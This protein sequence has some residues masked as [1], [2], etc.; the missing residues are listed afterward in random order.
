MRVSI[1]GASGF[2]GRNL[3]NECPPN[4]NIDAFYNS[5]KDFPSTIKRKRTKAIKC[6]LSNPKDVKV[7]KS[8][9]Y[10][11][12]IY[13]AGNTDPQMSF[14][15]PAF[16]LKSNQLSLVNFLENVKIGKIIYFSSGAVY[17]GLKGNVNPNSK[18][19]P[20]LAYSISK[21]SSEQ[22]VKFFKEKGAVDEY[23][24]VRFFG[25]Y[26]PYE[27]KRKITT[28]IVKR[29]FLEKKRD[30]QI[31]GSG[32]NLIDLMYVSD[33]VK[34]IDILSKSSKKNITVD[35]ANK[36]PVQIES[37]VKRC[38]SLF[39]INPTIKKKGISHESIGFRS[40]DTTI[41]RMGF[42]PKVRLEKGLGLLADHL[43][44]I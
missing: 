2:I 7:L 34:A 33:T 38:A 22:Y 21:L 24:I 1:V 35:L 29:F 30:I 5:S 6:D 27:P 39:N 40:N 20:K 44:K 8:K 37:L 36:N 12:C 19:D 11:L 32:K 31:Y 18:L 10:D 13:L 28:K 9:K 16:D 23:I 17:N 41:S 43:A 25:A 26:G 15:M 4:W 42:T 3:L 14:D